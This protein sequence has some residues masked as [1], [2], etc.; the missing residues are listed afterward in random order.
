[1]K[2]LI[3][4]LVCLVLVVAMVVGCGGDY[5]LECAPYEYETNRYEQNG[6]TESEENGRIA[7]RAVLADEEDLS[8]YG[9]PVEFVD[10]E[11]GRRIAIIP[12]IQMNDFRWI[13]VGNRYANESFE[14]YETGVLYEAGDLEAH[15]PFIVTHADLGT[16]PHRGFSF[17]DANGNRR[18]H[19]VM[20][21][22]AYPYDG[23]GIISVGHFNAD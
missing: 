4:I 10:H 7:W 22:N 21:N 18:Y 8:R 12:N 19:T 16:F 14:L 5:D 9:E 20:W 15:T 1:M 6:E 23:G 11:A 2:K 13:E 17:V 3:A